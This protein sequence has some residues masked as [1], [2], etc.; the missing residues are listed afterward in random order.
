MSPKTKY[1]NDK[2]FIN[3]VFVYGTLLKDFW[4][5]KRYLEGRVTRITP[6]KTKG[7]LYHLPEGYPGLLPGEG[8]T[9]GEVMEPVDE[10]LLKSLDSLEGYVVGRSNNLYNRD[11]QSVITEDGEEILCWVY[12]YNNE[13]FAK[14]NGI[15]VSDGDW[16]EFL[17][18]RGELI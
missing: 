3:K 14:E 11:V 5:Y 6:A 4:N 18:S 17:K 16:R 2:P 7:L 8:I 13:K 9:K 10:V 12:F 15:L 1:P